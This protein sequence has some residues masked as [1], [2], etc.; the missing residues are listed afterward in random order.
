MDQY[1][2]SVIGNQTR[3]ASLELGCEEGIQGG[4]C[5][6]GY[7]CVQQQQHLVAHAVD[8]ESS[9]DSSAR[10]LRAAVRAGEIERDPV[11]RAR[12]KKYQKSVLDSVLQDAKRLEGR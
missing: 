12:K 1:A 6:N 10:R 3:F 2:A 5:D 9:R 8:A 4:N 7:S 11:K